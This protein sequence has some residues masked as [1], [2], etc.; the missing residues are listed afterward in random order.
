MTDAL[1][2]VLHLRRLTLDDAKRC[3]ATLLNAEDEAQHEVDVAENA[4]AAEGA[5]AADP[6]MGDHVVEAYVAW[7]PV[8]R[9]QVVRARAGVHRV[10]MEISRARA[11]LTLAHAALEAAEGLAMRRAHEKTLRAQLRAQSV[12]D[13][14]AAQITTIKTG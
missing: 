14:L 11:A 8:G 13:E 6:S 5:V 12:E 9:A 4:L 7:L 10:Q 2:T 1:K 3:L